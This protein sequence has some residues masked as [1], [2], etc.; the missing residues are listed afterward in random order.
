MKTFTLALVAT[1]SVFV[2]V[3]AAGQFFSWGG[4]NDSGQLVRGGVLTAKIRR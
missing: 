2:V 3:A 1:L 4:D